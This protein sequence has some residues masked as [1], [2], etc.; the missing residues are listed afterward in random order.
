[1]NHIAETTKS[2]IGIIQAHA[3]L[4]KAL[5]NDSKP[6]PGYLFPE[7]AQLTNTQATCFVVL[8]QLLKSISP[9]NYSPD[10]RNTSSTSASSS[11]SYSSS[12]HVLLKAVKI[13]RQL[14]QSGSIEFRQSLARQGKGLLAELVGY[15]GSWDEVHGDRFNNDVRSVTEDLIEYMHANPVQVPDDDND[16]LKVSDSWT[17]R[18]AAVLKNSTQD[19]QGFGNPEYE[20]SSYEDSDDERTSSQGRKKK[21]V[22]V[23]KKEPEE[24]PAP[25]LPGF[26]NPAFQ[27]ENQSG[28]ATLLTKLFDRIQDLTAPPP[29]IAMR[30]AYREQE[31]RRQMMYVGDY[32]LHGGGESGSR[33]NLASEVGTNP[34]KRTSRI[35]GMA[36]GGWSGGTRDSG[37]ILPQDLA[38]NRVFPEYRPGTSSGGV[39]PRN[40]TSATVYALAENAKESYLRL[41]QSE[42]PR[43]SFVIGMNSVDSRHGHSAKEEE[44]YGMVCGAVGQIRDI[45]LEAIKQE[46]HASMSSSVSQSTVVTELLR[47]LNDWIGSENWE[48]RLR[49]LYVIEGLLQVKEVNQVIMQCPVVP[50]LLQTLTGPR[51]LSAPQK[52]IAVLSSNLAQA[53]RRSYSPIVD[54]PEWSPPEILGSPPEYSPTQDVKENLL[55]LDITS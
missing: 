46:H 49:Y 8:T 21:P 9:S 17:T 18:E 29:P 37:G 10:L 1:M 41:A 15:R 55:L 11:H 19:L 31:Q 42:T 44:V 2:T 36:A 20:N 47:D 22:R 25:P 16:D 4:A 54:V 50:T 52:S 35:Q 27:N 45:V 51:C 40:E 24:R 5:S 28:E 32:N 7:I 39:Q 23:S 6:T 33:L 12:A 3:L 26:G 14:A 53:F 30:A 43:R 38:T 48:R 34:F 13:L